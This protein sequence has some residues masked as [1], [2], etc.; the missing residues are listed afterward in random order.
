MQPL[1]TVLLT[2]DGGDDVFL[3]YRFHRQFWTAQRLAGVLPEM[4]VPR[5]TLAANHVKRSWLRPEW[6]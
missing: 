4:A 3:G 2:G 1:A 6:H 5:Y